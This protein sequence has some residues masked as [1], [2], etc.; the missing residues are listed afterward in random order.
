LNLLKKTTQILTALA[1]LAGLVLLMYFKLEYIQAD[2]WLKFLGSILRSLSYFTVVSNLLV[3]LGV[4][5]PLLWPKRRAGRFF[6]KPQTVTGLL[7]YLAIVGFVY[8]VAVARLWNPQGMQKIVDVIQHDI[9]PIL[10]LLYWI[11]TPKGQLSWKVIF[12]WLLLPAVYLIFIL[13]RGAITNVYPYPFVDVSQLGIRQVLINAGLLTLGFV[14]FG[15]A[16]VA[17]D[18]LLGKTRLSQ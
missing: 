14:V 7:V 3:V 1:G 17:L 8:H 2:L 5:I 10:F 16:A 4:T 11:F 6:S 15:M 13:V 18:R 9:V 12:S